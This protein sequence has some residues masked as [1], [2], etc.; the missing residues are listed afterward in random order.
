[1]T[2]DPDLDRAYA[3][4][5]PDDS[6]A[7][8][9]AWAETYDSSFVAESGYKLHLEVVMAFKALGGAGPVLD[10]GAGTGIVGVALKA[11][12]L[13]PVDGTDISPEMLAQAETK[14]VYRHLFEGDLTRRLPVVEGTYAGAVSAGTFTNGHVGPAA[15][16]EVLR[17]V[18]PGGWIT[19][20]VNAVHWNAQGFDAALERISKRISERRTADV[21]IYEGGDGPHAEDRAILLSLRRA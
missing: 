2:K 21:A 1:M 15:L 14:G 7:L 6:R 10:L 9:A 5:T 17:V 13:G 4:R 12:G 3:L 18:A 11:Q 16:D 19:L 20:S 8:Y